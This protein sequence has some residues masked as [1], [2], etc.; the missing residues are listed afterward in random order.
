MANVG[1]PRERELS[2]AQTRAAARTEDGG[3]LTENQA[4]GE[5][6]RCGSSVSVDWDLDDAREKVEQWRAEY[7]EM[8]P[9]GAIGDR[10]WSW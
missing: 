3:N 8:R 4:L 5:T 10:G 9:H 1:V 7:N 6:P 2:A